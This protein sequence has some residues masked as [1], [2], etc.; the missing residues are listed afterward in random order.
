M[1][2]TFE[3]AAPARGLEADA[4][5]ERTCA[6]CGARL[7]PDGHFCGWCGNPSLPESERDDRESHPAGHFLG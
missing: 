4:D 2:A 1:F 7:S 6:L 3:D 5:D